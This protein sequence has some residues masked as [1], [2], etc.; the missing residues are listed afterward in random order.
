[1]KTLT[2]VLGILLF[3]SSS[4]AGT[5]DPN[6]LDS[7]YIEYGEKFQHTVKLCCFDGKG[8]SC[9][10]AVV[11][12]PHW[13]I[14]AAHVVDDCQTWTVTVK[15]KAYELSKVFLHPQYKTDIFGYYDIALCY[16]EEEFS[17]DG[18]PSLYESRD[19]VGKIC[20]MAGW[21]NTGN[22]NTGANLAD[23]TR[24]GGSNYVDS[25]Q[26]NVLVCSPSKKHEK[27]TELEFLIASGDSGGGL[28]IDGKLAG[29][30]SSLMAQDGK[31]NGTYTDQSCHTRVSS[32]INWIKET[33]ETC[34]EKKE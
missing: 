4:F 12:A 21:G 28:F 3:F 6:T 14:T 30:H 20:C 31:P 33:M 23:K 16:S 24:R 10:S 18:Y 13:I 19:E 32:Y 11:I 9:G 1:M 34:N 26:R 25:I 5:I 15:D 29:I 27:F 22:F 7:K 8:V 2:F 17:F